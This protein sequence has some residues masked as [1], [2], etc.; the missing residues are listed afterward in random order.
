MVWRT[1][2]LSSPRALSIRMVGT[3]ITTSCLQLRRRGSFVLCSAK[4]STMGE[5]CRGKAYL[6]LPDTE[7]ISQ[8]QLDTFKTSGPGGQHRN[9]TESAVRLKHLPT[10][11][12][13]QVGLS[14]LVFFRLIWVWPSRAKCSDYY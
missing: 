12:I 4:Y 11:L 2:F 13:A 10:G 6:E 3:S 9:K 1:A 14:H 5:E 7:L 8:C